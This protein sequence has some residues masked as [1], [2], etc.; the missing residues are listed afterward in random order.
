MSC[1]VL[2]T[3]LLSNRL[4]SHFQGDKEVPLALKTYLLGICMVCYVLPYCIPYNYLLEEKSTFTFRAFCRHF[5][6]KRLTMSTFVKRKKR[7]FIAVVRMFIEQVPSTYIAR[8]YTMLSA[9][10]EG[11]NVQYTKIANTL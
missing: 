4:V 8:C 9:I 7:Q 6:P 10:F 3:Y 5:Y 2:L 11:H 1:D